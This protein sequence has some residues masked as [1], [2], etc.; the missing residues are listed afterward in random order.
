MDLVLYRLTSSELQARPVTDIYVENDSPNPFCVP[1]L[2]IPS[3]HHSR[4]AS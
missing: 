3:C 2:I 1:H 4:P